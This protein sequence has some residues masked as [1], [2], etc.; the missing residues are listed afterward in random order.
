MSWSHN[1]PLA[2]VFMLLAGS[3]FLMTPLFAQ[4]ESEELPTLRVDRIPS[5]PAF[6]GQTRAAAAEKS[7]YKVE[8]IASGLSAPWALAFLPGGEILINEYVGKKRRHS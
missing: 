3:S 5:A 6:S 7:A 8:T 1:L 4:D 2:S